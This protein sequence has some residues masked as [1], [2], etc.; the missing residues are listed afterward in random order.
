MNENRIE[1]G[2]ENSLALVDVLPGQNRGFL[3]VLRA[4]P[5]QDKSRLMVT[6]SSKLLTGVL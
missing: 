4:M 6:K 2:L 5:G 3:D 1:N